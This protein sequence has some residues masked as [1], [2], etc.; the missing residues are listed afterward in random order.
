VNI[1]DS[2]GT[3]LDTA[4]ALQ[5][6]DLLVSVDTMVAHLGGALGRPV[7]MILSAEPEM[8][9]MT[10]RA[11]SPWYPSMRIFR[12][13]RKGDWSVMQRVREALE[14]AKV[15]RESQGPQESKSRSV[16][17]APDS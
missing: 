1:E 6:L 14:P 11:D 2:D 5:N 15:R 10:D 17:C 7:W 9:W 12:Q 16:Y 3:I 13:E 4:A 8:R